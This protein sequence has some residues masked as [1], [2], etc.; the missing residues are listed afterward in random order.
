MKKKAYYMEQ[1]ILEYISTY[2]PL[3]QEEKS[4]IL[5]EVPYKTF[6]KGT[7][8]LQEGQISKE[9]YFTIQ[10]LIR[11]YELI[12]GEEKSTY[13]YSEGEAIVAFESAS[14]QVPCKFSWICEEDTTV[15]IGRLD[16]IEAAY[17]KNPKLEKMSRLFINQQFGKYQDVS[18]SFITLDPEQRYLQLVEKRPD[19]LKR[20]AQYHLA[21]YLGI[22]PETLSR[23]RKR[24]AKKI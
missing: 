4:S 2:V 6:K 16:G 15:V 5:K 22:K 7:H 3:T 13:F 19:L 1:K 18:T 11:Q 17:A 10:G 8:L 24:I 14:K 20:V 21:S 9:C 12:E 23:I